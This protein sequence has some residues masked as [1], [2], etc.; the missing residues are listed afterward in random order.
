MTIA[1]SQR[2][3]ARF[4]TAAPTYISR[5][6]TVGSGSGLCNPCNGTG[7]CGSSKL[8]CGDKNVAAAAA[9]LFA[10]LIFL[11]P[12]PSGSGSGSA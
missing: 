10:A 3:S 12:T 8:C 4:A 7:A 11:A 2:E 1:A 5:N 9:A 6:Q